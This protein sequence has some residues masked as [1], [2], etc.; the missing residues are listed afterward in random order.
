LRHTVLAVVDYVCRLAS[1]HLGL[2][3]CLLLDPSLLDRCFVPFFPS[4]F[5][6]YVLFGMCILP[7]RKLSF[8]LVVMV[9][10]GSR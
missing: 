9:T 8:N 10:E 4:G 6:K 3:G 1:R 2:E 5:S 7:G